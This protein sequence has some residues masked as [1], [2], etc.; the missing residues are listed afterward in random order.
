M[1]Q[2]KVLGGIVLTLM[3]VL[4]FN[5]LID[6]VNAIAL[7]AENRFDVILGSWF[8]PIYTVSILVVLATTIYWAFER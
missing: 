5:P 6:E 8:P 2:R 3:L 4:A 7:A 1:D